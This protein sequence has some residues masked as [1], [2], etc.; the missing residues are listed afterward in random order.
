MLTG[1]PIT[2]LT[3]RPELAEECRSSRRKN[4]W[5]DL[6]KVTAEWFISS[7]CLFSIYYISSVRTSKIAHICPLTKEGEYFELTQGFAS[8]CFLW[9]GRWDCQFCCFW[10]ICNGKGELTVG[11]LGRRKRSII[12]TF[13]SF[14]THKFHNQYESKK[15]ERWPI[16]FHDFCISIKKSIWDQSWIYKIRSDV[17]RREIFKQGLCKIISFF[18][19]KWQIF[20]GQ[21]CHKL[22]FI[23]VSFRFC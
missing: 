17:H 7:F 16:R 6:I 13:H 18:G 10:T 11:K 9:G 8:S 22:L 21:K 20:F 4:L 19:L 15:L 2:P 23:R 3:S 14:A 5:K 1:W 12:L